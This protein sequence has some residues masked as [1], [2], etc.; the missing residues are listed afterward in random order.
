M[1]AEMM[2]QITLYSDQTLTIDGRA[3]EDHIPYIL[4]TIADA[5][6]GGM[7]LVDIPMN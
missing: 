3:K 5:I 1:N 2:L 7:E 6:E 4:R